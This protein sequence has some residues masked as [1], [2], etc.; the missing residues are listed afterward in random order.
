VICLIA[1]LRADGKVTVIEKGWD[2]QMN[3]KAYPQ[4]H[5]Y[6]NRHNNA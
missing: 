3:N 4:T 1:V 6:I 2:I 5:T